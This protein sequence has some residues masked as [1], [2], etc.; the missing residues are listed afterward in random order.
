MWSNGAQKT[1]RDKHASYFTA[2]YPTQGNAIGPKNTG[3]LW[4]TE[5]MRQ[6]V[7]CETALTYNVIQ[8]E[9]DA[10]GENAQE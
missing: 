4:G 9:T 1:A 7:V 10:P 6:L 2:D 5:I 8:P 3:P